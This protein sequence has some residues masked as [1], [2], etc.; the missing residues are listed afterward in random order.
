MTKYRILFLFIIFLNANNLLLYSQG[1][2]S[3][4]IN[5]LGG[6]EN[7][8]PGKNSLILG[9]SYWHLNSSA[10][11]V[12][13][14][15]ENDPLQ[16]TARGNNIILDL[17][18]GLSNLLSLYIS[19]PY[20][21]Y[22]RKTK[23]NSTLNELNNSGLS[24]LLVL[25]KFKLFNNF[26]SNLNSFSL[27]AGGK[28]PTGGTASEKDG[29]E[30]PLDLQLGSGSFD[31]YLWGLYYHFLSEQFLISQSFLYKYTSKNKNEYK[32][33]PELNLQTSFLYSFFEKMI[34][35]NIIVRIQKRWKDLSSNQVVVNSGRF[36]IELLPGFQFNYS[37]LNLRTNIGIPLYTLVGGK[38]LSILYRLG[39]EMRYSIF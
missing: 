13:N 4:S 16:R 34:Y 11:F 18:Y 27:G 31:I 5:S 25:L 8:S 24:D 37:G 20:N 29:V 14:K 19:I 7:V 28:F 26:W 6:I 22:Y 23:I 2:C 1:C 39:L 10:Y 12:D 35:A 32:F 9:I 21:F 3:I 30:L 15:K 33:G 36:L 17:E 38:Q